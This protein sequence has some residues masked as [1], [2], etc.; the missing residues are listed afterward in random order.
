MK[1]INLS[2]LMGMLVFISCRKEQSSPAPGTSVNSQDESPSV[3]WLV[4]PLAK[5]RLNE[6]SGTVAY[7]GIGG[8]NGTYMGGVTP[9]G[10]TPFLDGSPT[11]GFDGN[12]GFVMLP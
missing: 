6:K 8:F 4:K 2:L 10:G 12:S 7:D 11:A 3:A 5:W 1:K 9:G